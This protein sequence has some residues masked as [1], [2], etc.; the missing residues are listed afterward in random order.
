MFDRYSGQ[1]DDMLANKRSDHESPGVTP[2]IAMLGRELRLPL[3]APSLGQ[4]PRATGLHPRDLRAYRRC[5]RAGVGPPEDAAT[6][7]KVPARPTRQGV[8]LQPER[9]HVACDATK[10]E[11]RP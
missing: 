11:A 10:R 6:S 3:D 1:C 4:S 5:A 8:T 9:P 7:P 2:A